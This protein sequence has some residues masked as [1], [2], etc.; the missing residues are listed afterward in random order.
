MIRFELP[1]EEA[2]LLKDTAERFVAD[3]YALEQRAKALSTAPGDVPRHWAEMAELG[4]LAACV[5]EEAGGLGLT[6]AQIVPMMEDSWNSGPSKGRA[7]INRLR[8]GTI[9]KWDERHNRPVRD[10]STWVEREIDKLPENSYKGLRR[11]QVLRRLEQYL[12]QGLSK[13][14]ALKRLKD[15]LQSNSGPANPG[16]L[17]IMTIDD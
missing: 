3:N 15:S 11:E 2:L 4:W 16:K 6:P 10:G 14:D 8:A 17:A 1:T 5:P 12:K 7:F 13:P 9:T